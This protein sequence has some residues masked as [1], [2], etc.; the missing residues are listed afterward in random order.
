MGE[1]AVSGLLRRAVAAG[2]VPGAVAAWGSPDRLR[3]VAVGR[4]RIVGGVEDAAPET[5]YD[6]ASLTKPLAT[7]TLLLLARREL[8]LD[9]DAPLAE[10][11]PETRGR[12]LGE[13]PL[14]RLATHTAGLPAWAPLYALASG[15]RDRVLEALLALE[16]VAPPGAAVVYS[17]PGFVL[18]GLALERIWGGRD[19]ARLFADLVA[20]PLGVART[21][22]FAAAL[23]PGAPVAGGARSPA[24]ELGQLEALR[25]QGWRLSP[26]PPPPGVLPDDGNARF[27]GGAA[28]NS[29]LVGTAA[30]VARIAAEYLPGGGSLLR[31]GDAALATRCRTA[32]LGQARGLG[33]QLAAT[34]GCSAGP[35]LPPEAFGH[36]G[37]TGTSLWVDPHRRVVAVLLSNRHHPAHRGV[38]L[39]PLRRR[40]NALAVS[41]APS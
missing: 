6:L 34:P 24:A 8:G 27:L 12:W 33:W 17:C 38:D 9:L 19:L 1:E 7:V 13:V 10:I 18:L 21:V 39:H 28:G 5:R 16:P 2:M 11:L 32:G 35:T 3:V 14:W 37:F 22:G 4:G 23:P 15:R 26:V 29:G 25:R 41:C 40:F 31:S 36:T 30:A 20:A